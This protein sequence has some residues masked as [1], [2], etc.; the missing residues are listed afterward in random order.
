MAT[1]EAKGV[2]S[3]RWWLAHRSKK[4]VYKLARKSYF[5][6][7]DEGDGGFQDFVH[8]ENM[9]LVDT[10]GRLRGFYDGT[11]F[12]RGEPIGAGFRLLVRP[13]KSG[14]YRMISRC[15]KKKS[16]GGLWV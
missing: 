1:A 13:L 8:T 5:A 6:A 7:L 14:C 9:V 11:D 16:K 2:D 15:P 4:E 3:R 10:L 12:G